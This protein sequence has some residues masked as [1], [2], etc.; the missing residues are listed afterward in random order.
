MTGSEFL[1]R[2]RKIIIII[3]FLGVVILIG[4]F[5]F[6]LFFKPNLTTNPTNVNQTTNVGGLPT[7]GEGPGQIVTTTT[8]NIPGSPNNPTNLTPTGPQAPTTASAVSSKAQGGL[9]QVT[10]LNNLPSLG[11]TLNGDGQEAQ[12]YNQSDGKFY[13]INASGEAIPLTDKV[14]HNVQK[15]TWA[16]NN[17]KAALEYPDGSKIIYDFST[18]KQTTLPKHWQDI[19]FS[20]SSQQIV[21][22]SLAVDPENRYLAVA[23]TDTSQTLALEQIGTNDDKVY[24]DWSPNNQI[25]AL[26]TEG[27]DF[28]RQNLF[29]IGLNG[30]NFKSTLIEGRGFQPLWSPVGDKLLYSVYSTDSNLNPQLWIVDA[31]GDNI[32]NNRQPLSVETWANKCVFANNQDLYCAVPDQLDKGAG[33][34]PD[35]GLKT[36]DSLYKINVT[37]G[38]KKLIATPDGKYNISSL[39]VSK[40]QSNLYFTDATTK[41]IYKISLK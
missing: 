36:Q 35:L 22:K 3:L 4:F 26:Y 23:N 31:Q 37:T 27:L 34:F 9:T 11:L 5:I 18:N 20:P 30:E 19:N 2:Y 28:N 6:K 21:F 12:Y 15:V 1:N 16:P 10:S 17:N 38:Q 39:I 40:D 25:A 33:I 41:Q 7:A 32:G 29:F 13:K 14:F 24:T 8:G